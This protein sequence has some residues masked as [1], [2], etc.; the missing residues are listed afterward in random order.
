MRRQSVVLF[1]ISGVSLM[2]SLV[3]PIGGQAASHQASYVG[4]CQPRQLTLSV[5]SGSAGAGHVGLMFRLH[6]RGAQTCTLFGYPG[7]QL[8]N[9]RQQPLPTDL[10]WGMGSLSGDRARQVV[11]LGRGGNA[12]FVLEWAHSPTGNEA[13]P[14]AS[15]LR[16][17]PPNDYG[18]I[19]VSLAPGSIDACGGRLHASPVQPTRFP[20]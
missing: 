19:L 4:T 20:F 10:Q 9:A 2:A 7:A 1:L 3:W 13:C 15:Y 8:L 11:W 17:T 16:I 12:Y 5:V 6:N 18:T 14:H